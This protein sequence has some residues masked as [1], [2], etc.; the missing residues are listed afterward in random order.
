M[1]ISEFVLHLN[2]IY[3]WPIITIISL[4]IFKKPL[5][6]LIASL[7]VFNFKTKDIEVK[8]KFNKELKF[9]LAS[10]FTINSLDSE[11]RG[12]ESNRFTLDILL[13]LVTME[14]WNDIERVIYS[15]AISLDLLKDEN[16]S[17]QRIL[18]Q[19]TEYNVIK[20]ESIERIYRFQSLRNA[21]AHGISLSF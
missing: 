5:A 15:I 14:A 3:A 4:N 13:R 18:R 19:L 20:Q 16:L 8:L 7:E 1:T 17:F 21:L 11:K 10:P 6:N 9:I 12:R 2:K